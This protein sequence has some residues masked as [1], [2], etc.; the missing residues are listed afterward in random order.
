MDIRSALA[1]ELALRRRRE[2][3]MPGL[4]EPAWLILLDLA[5][6]RMA[7]TKVQV[8]KV[9]YI[10]MGGGSRRYTVASLERLGWAARVPNPDNRRS[11][12]LVITDEGMAAVEQCLGG[13]R[14]AA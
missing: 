14:A 3:V 9:G 1:N 13:L 8:S 7:G 6:C 5:C 10:P 11:V 12:W 2:L 4:R